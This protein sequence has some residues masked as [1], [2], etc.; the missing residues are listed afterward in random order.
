MKNSQISISFLFYILM[1][2]LFV[3]I[4][5]FG[6]I[7]LNT[8]NTTLSKTEEQKIKQQIVQEYEVCL[9]PL[10]KGTQRTLKILKN[11]FNTICFL[12]NDTSKIYQTFKDLK[13]LYKAS[14]N[15][16]LIDATYLNNG[17]ALKYKITGSTKT[18]NTI[19][20]TVCYKDTKK[21]TVDIKIAC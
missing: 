21:D 4:L 1:A 8:L 11:K 10:K 14:N 19:Q 3:A 18:E 12:A 9:N 2:V 13:S 15:I 20:K 6:A 16:A 5:T 17:T 7:Q